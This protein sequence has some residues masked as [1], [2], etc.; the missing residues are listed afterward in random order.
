MTGFQWTNALW[1]AIETGAPLENQQPDP[2]PA[3]AIATAITGG[4]LRGQEIRRLHIRNAQIKG[5][6]DLRQMRFECAVTLEDCQIYG[7]VAIAGAR[8]TSLSLRGSLVVGGIDAAGVIVESDLLL[9]RGFESRGCTLLDRARIGGSLDCTAGSFHASNGPALSGDNVRV[10]GALVLGPRF[11]AKGAVDLRR[12]EVGGQLRFEGVIATGPVSTMKDGK[13]V[14][15]SALNLEAA[16]VRRAAIL[17]PE[18]PVTGLV[19]VV[20]AQFAYLRDTQD[21]WGEHYKLFGVKFGSL[22]SDM[23]EQQ[24]DGFTSNPYDVKRRFNWIQGSIEKYHP[25]LYEQLAK[26]YHKTGDE[27]SA[28]RVAIEKQRQKSKHLPFMKKVGNYFQW[29]V[30]GYGYRSWLAVFWLALLYAV[31]VGL[32]SYEHSHGYITPRAIAGLHPNFHP[33]LYAAEL[34]LPIVNLGE[35]EAWSPTHLAQA[36]AIIWVLLGWLFASALVAGLSGLVRRANS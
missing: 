18:K 31:G 33:F 2:I 9:G 23:I 17:R 1:D 32:F 25:E 4:E 21:L 16:V 19:N 36:V 12:A 22:P 35:R 30:L 6:L 8:M 29:I 3:G 27:A 20:N 13:S 11:F 15:P 10:E 28:T 14:V 26:H 34:V 7:V 5:E 24:S